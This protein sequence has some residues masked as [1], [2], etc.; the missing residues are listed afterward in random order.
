L[1]EEDREDCE[2]PELLDEL[3]ECEFGAELV[4]AGR[5]EPEN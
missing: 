2:E 3:E 1:K 5:E 4:E